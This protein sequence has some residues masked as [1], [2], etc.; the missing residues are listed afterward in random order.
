MD[1]VFFLIG[2]NS[3][4]FGKNIYLSNLFLF[5]GFMYVIDN[6]NIKLFQF[7]I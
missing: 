3:R 4:Y 2:L 5:L 7:F 1:S 6:L